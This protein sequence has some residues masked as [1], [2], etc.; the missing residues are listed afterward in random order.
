MP[1]AVWASNGDA[2]VRARCAFCVLVVSGGW[3]EGEKK[4]RG[5]RKVGGGENQRTKPRNNP[6]RT[7]T[8]RSK[9]GY[10]RSNMTPIRRST[11]I[12]PMATPTRIRRL[13]QLT[14]LESECEVDDVPY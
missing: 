3:G 14:A 13:C 9:R 5:Q 8:L 11:M 10:S 7:R 4:R 2:H 1:C 12:R 6:S